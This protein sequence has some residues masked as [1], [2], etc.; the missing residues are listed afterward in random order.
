M[1]G[2]ARL[3][4]FTLRTERWHLTAW[5]LG[6]TALVLAS[7]TAVVTEFAAESARASIVAVAAANPAFLFL[8]GTPDGTSPGSV[9]FF[10]GFTFIAVLTGL[11]STF[12]VVRNTRANEDTGRAELVGALPLRRTSVVI[13][14]LGVLLLADV[15][16][17]LLVA[18]ALLA[19]G[20]DAGGAALTGLA[21]TSVGLV[22]GAVA[23]VVTQVM[24]TSRGANGA[25]AALVGVAYLARAWGD[26]TGRANAELTKVD[27]AWPSWLSPIGWAQ[28]V[29][30]F[31]EADVRP[32]LLSLGL[33][34]VLGAVAV[35]MQRGRDLGASVLRE[36]PGR[37]A[38]SPV[39]RSAVSLAF[40]AQWPTLVGWSIAA[41]VLGSIAGAL[42]PTVADA[43]GGNASL[44]ELIARLLPG[45]RAD[46]VDVFTTAILGICGVLAAAAGVQAVLRARAEEGEG[47][48]ELV[49]SAPVH[50]ARWLLGHV[51][52]GFF[53]VVVV[54][55]VAGCAAGLTFLL[56]GEPGERVPG[57]LAA[58]LA[59]V[60]AALVLVAASAL[61]YALAPR[62]A[63]AASWALLVLALVAGQF[64]DL[65][66]LPQEVRDLSPFAHSSA[67]PLEPLDGVAVIV[68]CGIAA[69]GTIVAV[70]AFRRRDIP[71]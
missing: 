60:P 50:R 16:L 18:A 2:T 39:L 42:A 3:A 44:R 21:T 10:Q 15:V 52:V 29:S 27:S 59:H 45:T 1:S 69:A 9:F 13:A 31:G 48:V 57:S 6:I 23:A 12:L 32:L 53:S 30:P 11:M 37:A 19:V 56:G 5:V 65:L 66:Q 33:T 8:R 14:V 64:G 68:L 43:I 17:G 55:T 71:V 54:A 20:L 24:P 35:A 22:F 25:S 70:I 38:A 41:A 4:L 61:L 28:A 36:R 63:I 49:L 62:V 34:A 58:A 67:L 47:R 26:A 40:R 51:L 7:A 46:T